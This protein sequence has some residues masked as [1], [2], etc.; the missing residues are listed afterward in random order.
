MS[1]KID[2]FLKTVEKTSLLPE[3]QTS[4]WNIVLIKQN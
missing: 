1:N 4:L 3:D 2:S